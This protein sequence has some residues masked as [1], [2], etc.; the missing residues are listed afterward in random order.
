[1]SFLFQTF[2]IFLKKGL[3]LTPNFIKMHLYQRSVFPYR[4]GHVTR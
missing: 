4:N 1:M 3:S 2:L